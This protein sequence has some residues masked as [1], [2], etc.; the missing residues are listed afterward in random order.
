MSTSPSDLVRRAPAA[1]RRWLA[2]LARAIALRTPPA[3]GPGRW[4]AYAEKSRLHAATL[5]VRKGDLATAERLVQPLLQDASSGAGSLTLRARLLH[6]QGEREQAIATL[7]RAGRLDPRSLDVALLRLQLLDGGPDR[8]RALVRAVQDVAGSRRDT[9]AVL[10]ALA[11]ADDADLA[12]QYRDTLAE[13]GRDED[14]ERADSIGTGLRLAR[15]HRTDRPGYDAALAALPAPRALRA[16]LRALTAVRAWDELAALMDELVPRAPEAMWIAGARRA[17]RAALRTGRTDAAVRVARHVLARS[18]DDERAL[19]VLADGTDQL[20]VV[21][22]R[23]RPPPVADRS[24]DPRP[25]A[26]LSVLSQS[27]PVRSGGYA[28]RTHGVLTGLAARGWDVQAVTRLGFPYDRWSP[29]DERTV[30]EQDVVDGIRYHRLL[31][32]GARSYPQY[33]LE[34]YVGSMADGVVRLAT[35]QRAALVHASSFY[36]TG[37]AAA[38]AARRL[39]LPFLYEMRGLE[40]LMKVSRDPQFSQTDRYRFLE[41]VETEVCLEA[42]AVLVITQA[43]RREMARRGVPEERMV[44]LPNGVHTAEFAPRE[45]DRE[46]AAELGVAD[47]PVIGYAG[48]LVDYEGLELLMDSVAELKEGGAAFRVV[49]VGDGPAERAVRARA[50]RLRLG[51]VVTFTGRVPH[52]Q[53]G[54]YLSLFD[55]TPFPRLPLPVCELISP[56]KPFEAMAMGKAVVVSSVAA[57]TEI[58]DADRTGLVFRKG[59]AQDLA[60]TLRRLLDDAPLRDRLGAAGLAW[61]RAERDWSTVTETADATYREVLARRAVTTLPGGR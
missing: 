35:A 26:V 37:L 34:R 10:D 61:V 55:I 9:L 12:E 7:E 57:L 44:V 14:A 42:D 6:L 3:S 1:P 5:A 52:D 29:Q 16:G 28:T 53:V 54:R 8:R 23:W 13:A 47:L 24:Y 30:P 38:A 39:G 36:V 60:A 31:P 33:P 20:D 21:A 22:R 11:E 2:R 41:H 46:L 27:L 49:L 58:V 43:L 15:L 18:P 40:D 45:R 50:D 51:D 25:D 59:D 48:G 56:M 17:A 4:R 19:A 32:D